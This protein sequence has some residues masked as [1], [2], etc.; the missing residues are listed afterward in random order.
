MLVCYRR[1]GG[2]PRGQLPRRHRL[3]CQQQEHQHDSPRPRASL[4]AVLVVAGWRVR[5]SVAR[6][7]RCLWRWLGKGGEASTASALPMLL[8]RCGC[9]SALDGNAPA[10]R[11]A[12][13]RCAA[14]SWWR[15]RCRWLLSPV[16]PVAS[17]VGMAADRCRF[18][19]LLL[20]RQRVRPRHTV[21]MFF[22][23][24]PLP[25]VALTLAP[26]RIAVATTGAS[27]WQTRAVSTKSSSM[28]G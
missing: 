14:R 6:R 1:R 7:A 27:R 10:A 4:A 22:V 12:T 20:Q 9:H 18:V 11:A 5:R 28:E 8:L 19:H 26:L 25:Y 17:H 16:R 3:P 13:H 21:R 15:L 24:T 2:R 23:L